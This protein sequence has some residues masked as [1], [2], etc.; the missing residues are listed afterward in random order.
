M[1][2]CPTDFSR[3]CP[4]KDLVSLIGLPEFLHHLSNGGTIKIKGGTCDDPKAVLDTW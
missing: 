1:G 2:L 3:L 4:G